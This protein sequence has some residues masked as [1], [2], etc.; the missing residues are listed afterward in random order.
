[1]YADDIDRP[2]QFLLRLHELNLQREIPERSLLQ[3]HLKHARVVLSLLDPRQR[4]WL[5]TRVRGGCFLRTR[6]RSYVFDAEVLGQ[7]ESEREH[8][9]AFD[10]VIDPR[11]EVD[12]LGPDAQAVPHGRLELRL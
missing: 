6:V 12:L 3:C 5:R 8:S 2:G 10:V 7:S 1:M 4:L 9:R 11:V